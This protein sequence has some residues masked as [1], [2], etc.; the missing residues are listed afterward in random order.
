MPFWMLAETQAAGGVNVPHCD[1]L[2][3]GTCTGMLLWDEIVADQQPQILS[4][5]EVSCR[6]GIHWYAIKASLC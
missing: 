6:G 4:H 2:H 3:A 5:T 1:R